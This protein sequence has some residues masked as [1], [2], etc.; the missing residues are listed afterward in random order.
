MNRFS[1][2][3]DGK[4]YIGLVAILLVLR[5][6]LYLLPVEFVLADQERMLSW[7][8]MIVVTLLGVVGVF[9]APR[10]GFARMW[11]GKVEN[12][13]RLI[14][15]GLI[16]LGFGILSVAQDALQ[17]L[18]SEMQIAFPASLVVYP[19]AGILEE[20]L[21][22]LFLTTLLVWLGSTVI[23]QGRGQQTV[24][25]VV[26][27]VVG[28][29]YAMLQM[30]AYT[31]VAGEVTFVVGVWFLVQIGGYFVMAAYVYRRYGFLAAVVMR[32]GNYLIWH[33]IWGALAG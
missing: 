24:F 12:R 33:I 23:L 22:R 13:R 16:G 4:V 27:V 30:A 18:E 7:L 5:L 17:P 14:I 8:S 26:A 31:M 32:M 25:W 6:L 3:T 11:D 10:A 1:L 28:L 9:L 2:S 20:I 29:V 15:P 19:L 21:F